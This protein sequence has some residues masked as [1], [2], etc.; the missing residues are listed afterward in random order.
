MNLSELKEEEL[1]ELIGEAKQELLKRKGV[2]RNPINIIHK[3]NATLESKIVRYNGGWVKR[4]EGL[5]KTR[6]DGY[7]IKGQ[8]VGGDLN[9]LLIWDDGLYL[10]C[11]IRGSRKNQEKYYTLFVVENNKVTVLAETG[12][13]DWAVNLWEPITAY[14]VLSL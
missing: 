9:R 10:D 3:L 5:D 6:T 13:K 14:L 11:D 12:G 1:V 8:F 4:V 2:E 7:S